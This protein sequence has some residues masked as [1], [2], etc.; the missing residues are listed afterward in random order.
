M[1]RDQMTRQFIIREDINLINNALSNGYDISIR[2]TDG[3]IKI[4]K[5]QARV[6]KQREVKRTDASLCEQERTI[7]QRNRT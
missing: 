1:S 4:L 7:A 3:G 2:R 5:E 6:L